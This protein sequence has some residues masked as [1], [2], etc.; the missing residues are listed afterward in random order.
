MRYQ[1]RRDAEA[2]RPEADRLVDSLWKTHPDPAEFSRIL[3]SDTALDD[4]L[5]HAAQ[6]SSLRRFNLTD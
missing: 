6:V 1:A 2:L 5:R 4:P 3:K